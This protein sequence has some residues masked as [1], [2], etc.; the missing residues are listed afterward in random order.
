MFFYGPAIV[1][2]AIGLPLCVCRSNLTDVMWCCG[3]QLLYL[4]N[5]C[6]EL[7]ARFNS[8]EAFFVCVKMEQAIIVWAGISLVDKLGD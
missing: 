3:M 8:M 6:V 2:M 5:A 4:I 7:G 1:V